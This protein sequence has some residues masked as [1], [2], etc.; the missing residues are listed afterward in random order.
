VSTTKSSAMRRSQRT[1][2]RDDARAA[3]GARWN[4]SG[5]GGSTRSRAGA[6][7]HGSSSR[8]SRIDASDRMR[9]GGRGATVGRCDARGGSGGGRGG[10]GGGAIDDFL[11]SG[12]GVD[13]A[14]GAVFVRI[15]DDRRSVVG[16]SSSIDPSARRPPRHAGVVGASLTLNAW[17]RWFIGSRAGPRA[18]RVP[19]RIARTRVISDACLRGTTRAGRDCWQSPARVVTRASVVHPTVGL[20]SMVREREV[21]RV[22]GD[23]R[24]V[25]PPL[26]HVD[27]SARVRC[28]HCRSAPVSSSE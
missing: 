26:R 25:E 24:F 9:G 16:A 18:V 17:L 11:G 5:S 27:C 20:C 7:T 8:G 12:G 6:T 15:I 10:S 19:P 3:R 28:P 21:T 1:E 2:S 14:R 4:A 23:A 13:V 22:P